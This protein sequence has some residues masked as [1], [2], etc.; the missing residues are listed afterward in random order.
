MPVID[1]DAFNPKRIL[2]EIASDE[3]QPGATRVAACR[4]YLA[5]SDQPNREEKAM[6]LLDQRTMEVLSR[7]VH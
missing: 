6:S 7:R 5:V 4:A 2:A 1:L 3:N